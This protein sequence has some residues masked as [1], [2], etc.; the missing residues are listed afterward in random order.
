M[1]ELRNGLGQ[2]RS[3]ATRDEAEREARRQRA[4]TWANVFPVRNPA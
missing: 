3:Y 1:F 2:V 4:F